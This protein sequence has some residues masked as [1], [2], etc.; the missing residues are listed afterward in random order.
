MIALTAG[1]NFQ[2]QGGRTR[3]SAD[4]NS[5][6]SAMS[7]ISYIFGLSYD[8][9][10]G[11]QTS[12]S[13][14]VHYKNVSL[15]GTSKYALTAIPNQDTD[16]FLKQQFLGIGGVLKMYPSFQSSWW[17]GGGIQ[18][19]K[20]ISGTLKYGG[21]NEITLQGSELP[22]FMYVFGA[23]GANFPLGASLFL[24]AEIRAGALLI[25]SPM[26]YEADALLSLG[27]VF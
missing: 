26:I 1:G 12:L 22:S 23:I 11:S 24:N 7:G 10:L 6:I 5:S 27:Y 15:T 3:T 2:Y 20:A 14:N 17:W 18:Y 4:G 16:T 19:D 8:F 25:A 13:A 21:F 9:P